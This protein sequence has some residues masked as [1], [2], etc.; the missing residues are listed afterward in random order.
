MSRRFRIQRTLAGLALA[1]LLLAPVL[2]A[3]KI[4]IPEDLPQQYKQWLLEVRLII[5]KEEKQTFLALEKDYQRDAFIER[6]WRIRDPYPDTARNEFKD[7]WDVRLREIYENFGDLTGERAEVMLLNGFPDAL[8]TVDCAE[9][10][11][12]QVWYYRRAETVGGEIVLLFYQPGGLG[13]YRLWNPADGP[14]VLF[15]FP[16]ADPVFLEDMATTCGPGEGDALVGALSFASRQG[17]M[18]FMM[19]A[20]EAMTPPQ[21]PSGEW[22]QT[23]GAYSTE[24]PEGA[25]TF[26]A[27]VTFEYPGKHKT[28][29]VVQGLI[30]VDHTLLQTATLGEH[31]SYNLVLVG[32]VLRGDKLFDSFRYSFNHPAASIEAETIPFVFERYLR[33]GD[34]RMILRLEDSN[35]K[36]YFRLDRELDVPRVEI[37]YSRPPQDEESARILAE[38]NAAIASGD[39]TL[40]I[41]PPGD[42]LHT[43]KLRVDTLAVGKNIAK[44]EFALDGK[45]VLTKNL[46]PYSVELD[47]GTLPR[48][49]K[50][51]ATAFDTGGT[52]VASDQVLLNS[53]SHRFD[54]RLTEPRRG[55]K[56]EHSVRAE[57]EVQVPENR[58]VERVE[59]YLNEDLVAS[60]YQPP[61]T[62]PIVLPEVGQV[63]YVRVAAYQPDGN[64]SED[65]VFINAP[66]YLE[67]V[68][69]QFVELYVSVLNRQLRPVD[70]L[71]EADFA[72]REDGISQ[73][74]LRFDKVSNLP[75]HAGIL[76][77]VSASMEASLESAQ[78]AALKFFKEAI[79][80][81]D[82]ATLITFNDH[83]H[84]A[85]KFTN[86]VDI[87]AGGLAGLRAERGTALYDS[88]IFA[89][90]Y[91][92]G[93]KG[94]RALIILSDGKDEHSRFSFDHTLEYA[95][96]AGVAIYSIGLNLTKKQGDT[97][98]QL[99]RLSEET[100]G[101]IF[102][103]QDI[104]ELEVVYREIQR[105][106][107][108]RYYLAYQSTNISTSDDFRSIEVE[109]A[110]SG[111][112]AKTLRGYY[113]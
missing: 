25:G 83:P 7:K 36:S 21:G 66:D 81:R 73:T 92:N 43:G 60:L 86:D 37:V 108:S 15:R 91:F 111:L 42:G 45:Q 18:G 84:L 2:T 31:E 16:S 55:G 96:R 34:Y 59:F 107:R 46:P 82:R 57:A 97:P 109:L 24:I 27:E 72:I 52:R 87:L 85:A 33:A 41:V 62:F 69:V 8:I 17:S 1:S 110:E 29:T 102:L 47:M 14:N 98:K 4:P 113:P 6:F 78:L 89:L 61:Y 19:L 32:E 94:Q 103:I 9:I 38:A 88:L 101:R 13:R 49:R 23:F 76:V 44:V 10:W 63:A 99:R 20:A 90:Y 64:S 106:L 48:M 39:T 112:E 67:E 22:A 26:P 95:R 93:I 51:V 65:L 54:V 77:D 105:E 28:R 12:S 35:A 40:R 80:Q 30:S 3:K 68:E 104:A 79:T 74:P 71:S 50:L 11:P 100:G 53:G 5:T 56:Y 75:I 70:N 58:V